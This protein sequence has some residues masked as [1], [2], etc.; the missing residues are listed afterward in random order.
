MAKNKKNKFVSEE[1]NETINE[2]SEV[3]SEVEQIIPQEEVKVES[4]SSQSIKIVRSLDDVKTLL[5][6]EK[7]SATEKLELLKNSDFEQV[8]FVKSLIKYNNDMGNGVTAP[9]ELNGANNN[10][11]LF[12]QL[13]KIIDEIDY[14]VF[15]VKFD[16]VNLVFL[17]FSDDAYNEFKLHRY[18]LKWSGT[19]KN[20]KTYQKLVTVISTLCDKT[21]RKEQLQRVSLSKMIDPESTT[22]TDVARSNILRFY[23]E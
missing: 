20:L 9:T 19:S 13:M 8:Q 1:T 3:V 21:T 17:V 18:D 6:D 22:F 14:T 16:I 11:S 12:V 7:I 4:T 10:R 15:K 23:G 5:N 2:V